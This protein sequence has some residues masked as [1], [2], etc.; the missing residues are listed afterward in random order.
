MLYGKKIL[1]CYDKYKEN[2]IFYMRDCEGGKTY[3]PTIS[4]KIKKHM[5]KT[6]IL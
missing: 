4:H 3:T 2:K 5:N 1:V 6:G